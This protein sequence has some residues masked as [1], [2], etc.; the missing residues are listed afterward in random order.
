GSIGVP[1]N[2]RIGEVAQ[3]APGGPETLIDVVLAADRERATLLA[4]AASADDGHRI[5]EIQTRLADIGAHAAEARAARI[6][7]GLG[8]HEGAPAAARFALLRRLG[9]RG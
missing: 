4:E 1:R 2:W 6:L 5:A 9:T 8:F 7:A 3:E